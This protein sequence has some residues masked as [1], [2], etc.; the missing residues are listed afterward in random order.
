MVEIGNFILYLL[1]LFI[2]GSTGIWPQRLTFARGL[3][4]DWRQPW[5]MILVPTHST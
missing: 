3:T 5:T 2:F 1:I 4:F